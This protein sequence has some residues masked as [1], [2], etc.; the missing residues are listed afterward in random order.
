MNV[1]LESGTGDH[2]V[3]MFASSRNP[4]AIIRFTHDD[5]IVV[6]ESPSIY[7]HSVGFIEALGPAIPCVYVQPERYESF[8]ERGIVEAE[9]CSP[10]LACLAAIADLYLGTLHEFYPNGCRR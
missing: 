4:S 2:L 9:Q 3:N 10:E 1:Q 5:F 7:D 6:M 8:A